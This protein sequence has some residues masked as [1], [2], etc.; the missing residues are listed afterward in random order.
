MNLS[1]IIAVSG[2]H[3]LYKTVAQTKNGIIAESLADKKRIPV[4]AAQK[5][6]TL[7]AISVYLKDSEIPLAEVF[8]K[9]SDKENKGPAIDHKSEEAELT[10]YFATILPDYDKEK[11][12]LSDIRKMLHWYNILQKADMLNFEEAKTEAE[13]EGKVEMKT[14]NTPKPQYQQQK[15]TKTHTKAPTIQKQTV[16]KTGTA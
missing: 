15:Q 13:D 12:H 10:A 8:K 1:E 14:E 4:Y 11:V 9:I 7:E 3:G 16:R 5:V 6:H 2:I